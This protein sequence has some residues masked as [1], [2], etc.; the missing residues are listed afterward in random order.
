M[1]FMFEIPYNWEIPVL[2]REF[3]SYRKIYG[4]RFASLGIRVTDACQ[5]QRSGYI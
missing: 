2:N 4:L 3:Q 5:G 1:L